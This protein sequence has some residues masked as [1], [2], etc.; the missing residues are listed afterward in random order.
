MFRRPGSRSQDRLPQRK[1][2]EIRYSSRFPT[3]HLDR[4]NV[5]VENGDAGEGGVVLV[6]EVQL[7]AVEA[8]YRFLRS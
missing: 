2:F 5:F 7:P 8:G 6:R 3:D 1:N 4:E